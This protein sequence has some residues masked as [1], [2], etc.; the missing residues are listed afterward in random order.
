MCC[1]NVLL[2]CVAA[3]HCC[4]DVLQCMLQHTWLQ[5]ICCGQS[6]AIY[7]KM[8]EYVAAH[9]VWRMYRGILSSQSPT[10][11]LSMIN[12]VFLDDQLGLSV[13]LH[14]HHTVCGFHNKRCE[15]SGPHTLIPR[16]CLSDTVGVGA[17]VCAV[18]CDLNTAPL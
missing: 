13:C 5:R 7:C 8:L 17:C 4:C 11:S 3:A 9:M 10:Y 12:L 18:V 1:S 14:T 2:R 15:T 16:S 6:S